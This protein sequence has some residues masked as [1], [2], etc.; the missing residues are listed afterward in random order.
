MGQTDL[1]WTVSW[2]ADQLADT[3]V[4]DVAESDGGSRLLDLNVEA[5]SARAASRSGVPLE[6]PEG[7]QLVAEAACYQRMPAEALSCRNVAVV[8]AR[9]ADCLGSLSAAIPAG[10]ELIADGLTTAAVATDS[11]RVEFQM[12]QSGP[13]GTLVPESTGVQAV[14]MGQD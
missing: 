12:K 10:S 8:V 11:G 2:A 14:K 5:V 9:T 1:Y 6:L 4:T 3:A 13:V 7:N